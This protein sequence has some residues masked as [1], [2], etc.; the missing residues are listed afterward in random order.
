M[1]N[2]RVRRLVFGAY[3]EKTGAAGSRVDL[4]A[5]GLFNHDVEITGGVLGEECGVLLTSFFRAKRGK[6]QTD[7]PAIV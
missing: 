3:D 7:P 1:I 4:F 6:K 5:K 2:A